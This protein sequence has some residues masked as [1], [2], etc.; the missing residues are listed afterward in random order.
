MAIRSSKPSGLP[1]WPIT[2][3]AGGHGSGKTFTMLQASESPAISELYVLALGEERPEEQGDRFNYEILDHD[4]TYESI[5]EAIHDVTSEPIVDKPHAIGVDSMGALWHLIVGR[6]QAVATAAANEAA[7]RARRPAPPKV[8]IPSELWEE[9]R[10]EWYAIFNMLREYP[11]PVI[12]TARYEEAPVRVG[13]VVTQQVK[14]QIRAHPDLPY[15]VSAVIEMA[16]RGDYTLTK[17]RSSRIQFDKPIPMPEFTFDGF[18]QQFGVT[19]G[20]TA[21]RRMA[22]AVT[23]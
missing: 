20:P 16:Q 7:L 15:D 13:G 2:L 19:S 14:W 1:S 10:Q 21:P 6:K 12:L 9:A 5:Y 11:G 17:V 4:G 3:L 22:H 8:D 23:Q 18:W